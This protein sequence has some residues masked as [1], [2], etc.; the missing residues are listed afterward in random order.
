LLRAQTH[1]H[2]FNANETSNADRTA[3][4]TNLSD[5]AKTYLQT[6]D[7]EKE[8][9]LLFFHTVA[10]LHAPTYRVENAGALRQDW[11]RIPLPASCELLEQSA[12]L[13]KRIAALLD[14]ETQVSGVTSGSI[15]A[16]LRTIAVIRRV[17]GAGSL[18][19]EA[20]DLELHAGWGHRGKGN[21]VMPGKGQ[22]PTRAYSETEISAWQDNEQ[23]LQAMLAAL[24]DETH[25]VYLNGAA[26]WMNVPARVWEYTIGGYQVIK[27]WL[28]YREA[29]ILGR[30]LTTE[31]AREVMQMARRIAA[32]LMLESELDANYE[33]VKAHCYNWQDQTAKDQ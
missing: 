4:Q 10:L 14:T 27:K 12:A 29:D 2:L 25:D 32:I 16:E 15:R 13:G 28:S 19:P 17:D 8:A 26:A 6:L 24:G 7:A 11:P 3:T 22:A 23:T 9:E 18:N 5:A 33:R 20:G 21:V 31:E 30:G 1:R